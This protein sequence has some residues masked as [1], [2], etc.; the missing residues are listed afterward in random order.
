M[1]IIANSSYKTNLLLYLI[2]FE[3]SFNTHLILVYYNE[4]R[5]IAILFITNVL[6]LLQFP[7]HHLLPFIT[8]LLHYLLQFAI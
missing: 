2:L 1:Q 6:P 8:S 7:F 3:T 5:F 4:I